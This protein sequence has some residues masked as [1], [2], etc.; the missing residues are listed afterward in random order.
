VLER[1]GA[2]GRVE[3]APSAWRVVAE[4]AIRVLDALR[5]EAAAIQR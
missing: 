2:D 4:E 3:A 1:I 5:S